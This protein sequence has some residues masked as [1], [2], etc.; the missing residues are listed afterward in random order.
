MPSTQSDSCSRTSSSEHYEYSSCGR[1]RKPVNYNV[2][3]MTDVVYEKAAEELNT[4]ASSRHVPSKRKSTG[5]T[6]SS[7]SSKK[8]RTDAPINLDQLCSYDRISTST[9]EVPASKKFNIDEML[10]A[11]SGGF[12]M[13]IRLCPDHVFFDVC[14]TI[15]EEVASNARMFLQNAESTAQILRYAWNKMSANERAKWEMMARLE[16]KKLINVEC[17]A[18][19]NSPAKSAERREVEDAVL[20]ISGEVD[21]DRIGSMCPALHPA[22]EVEKEVTEER[23]EPGEA[24][25]AR[26][27]LLKLPSMP[28]CETRFRS[29]EAMDADERDN[30]LSLGVFRCWACPKKKNIVGVAAFQVHLIE[31]HY[32]FHLYGCHLCLEAFSCVD[33][34]K[35]HPCQ[36]FAAYTIGLLTSDKQFEMKHVMH[37]L[38]CAECNVQMPLPSGQNDVCTRKLINLMRVHS[39]ERLI[40]CLVFFPELPRDVEFVTVRGMEIKSAI[41]T[42]CSECGS[43]FITVFDIEKHAAE[44]AQQKLKCPM[45]PRFFFTQLFY[46]DHLA[47]HLGDQF[48]VSPI[49]ESCT[50]VPPA[51]MIHGSTKM[52]SKNQPVRGLLNALPPS[53]SLQEEVSDGEDVT[54]ARDILVRKRLE[55]ETGEEKAKKSKEREN[56]K[57]KNGR[58]RFDNRCIFCK[59]LKQLL[60]KSR[61]SDLCRC[62][63]WPGFASS[64]FIVTKSEDEVRLLMHSL[65]QKFTRVGRLYVGAKVPVHDTLKG[66]IL[67][68]SVYICVKCNALHVGEQNTLRHLRICLQRNVDAPDPEKS[69]DLTDENVAL[70]LTNP[71]SALN[72]RIWCPRCESKCCSIASLRRHLALDHGIF[73]HFN[74][75]EVMRNIGII[76][77]SGSLRRLPT[78]AE[79]TN[80]KL[81][82]LKSG[83]FK[84]DAATGH[85]IFPKVDRFASLQA[86]N[87]ASQQGDSYARSGP[88]SRGPPSSTSSS[89]YSTPVRVNEQ[90]SISNN[91]VNMRNEQQSLINGKECIVCRAEFDSVQEVARH[92]VHEHVHF[93]EVC[94]VAFSEGTLLEVHRSSCTP[95]FARS[96]DGEYLPFCGICNFTLSNPKRYFYHIANFHSERFHFDHA[97]GKLLPAMMWKKLSFPEVSKEKTALTDTAS[98]VLSSAMSQPAHRQ[99]T[100]SSSDVLVDSGSTNEAELHSCFLCE[101][102]FACENI[103]REHLNAHEERWMD[104]PVCHSRGFMTFPI[105]S[106]EDL[107]K[108]VVAKHMHRSDSQQ[109]V[110]MICSLCCTCIKGDSSDPMSIRRIQEQMFRHIIYLCNGVNS[111]FVCNNGRNIRPDD[112]RKHRLNAHSNIYERFGCSSCAKKFF[113]QSDFTSHLCNTRLRC[114]CGDRND[115]TEREFECHFRTHVNHMGDFCLLCNKFLPSKQ[116]Q[117]SHLN[118]HRSVSVGKR[119]MIDL[120][121]KQRSEKRKPS[122][123]KKSEE[124]GTGVQ[125]ASSLSMA[126]MKQEKEDDD[127]V[128]V[129]DDLSEGGASLISPPSTKQVS[130]TISA[131]ESIVAQ[132]GL[133]GTQPSHTVPVPVNFMANVRM[134]QDN[135]Y[136]EVSRVLC[137]HSHEAVPLINILDETDEEAIGNLVEKIIAEV[138]GET[139]QSDERIAAS[140]SSCTS[141]SRSSHVEGNEGE[142]LNAA[143]EVGETRDD[144]ADAEDRLSSNGGDG[145]LVIDESSEQTVQTFVVTESTATEHPAALRPLEVGGEEL[146]AVVEESSG[147]LSA[148]NDDDEVQILNVVEGTKSIDQEQCVSHEANEAGNTEVGMLKPSVLQSCNL[149]EV[150]DGD[151]DLQVIAA[152]EGPGMQFVK[153]RAPHLRCPHCT[154]KFVTRASLDAHIASHRYDAGNTIAS[155]YGVPQNQLVYLCRLCCLAYESKT[156][157]DKH[158]RTHGLMQNCPHCCVVTFIEEQMRQHLTQHSLEGQRITYICAFC[159]NTYSSDERLCHHMMRN[160]RMVVMYFCKN[161]GIG[162]TNGQLVYLHIVRNECVS[163]QVMLVQS[164]KLGVAPASMFHYQ[165][166]DEAGYVDAVNQGALVV[167]QPSECVH[168]SFLMPQNEHVMVTC[169]DCSGLMS[170]T[171]LQSEKPSFVTSLPR[172]LNRGPDDSSIT[173]TQLVQIWKS[174]SRQKGRQAASVRQPN[175]SE[176]SNT[177]RAKARTRRRRA[178]TTDVQQEQSQSLVAGNIAVVAPQQAQQ[179]SLTRAT[180]MAVQHSQS[181]APTSIAPHCLPQSVISQAV[182]P[183]T[184]VSQQSAPDA[185]RSGIHH[186]VV[187]SGNA[188]SN[189]AGLPAFA[190]M[191]QSLTRSAS[192]NAVAMR[193]RTQRASGPLLPSG[194]EQCSTTRLQTFLREMQQ[195]VQRQAPVPTQPQLQPSAPNINARLQAPTAQAIPYAQRQPRAVNAHSFMSSP[196][197]RATSVATSGDCSLAQQTG[198]SVS[199][200]YP[201]LRPQLTVTASTPGGQIPAERQYFAQRISSTVQPGIASDQREALMGVSEDFIVRNSRGELICKR[202]ECAGIRIEKVASGHVHNL[203]HNIQNTY[204]CL[205]CGRAFPNEQLAIKHQIEIHHNNRVPAIMLR[206]PF[207]QWRPIFETMHGFKNHLVSRGEHIGRDLRFPVRW[208]ECRCELAFASDEARRVHEKEHRL[209]KSS[210]C[211][212]LCGTSRGFWSLPSTATCPPLEHTYI[213]AF[214]LWGMCRECG[215][216]FPNEPKKEQFVRHYQQVHWVCGSS[217]C[218]VCDIVIHPHYI[219]EHALERHFVVGIKTDRMRPFAVTVNESLLGSY[220]GLVTPNDAET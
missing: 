139:E 45:C 128:I 201:N 49:V 110:T 86:S 101:K 186:S 56:G 24:E 69:F 30:K 118:F 143:P 119:R 122:T 131:A 126:E 39:C 54:I 145:V 70:R 146:V 212:L 80:A 151:D 89:D 91:V 158:M 77:W 46:R 103:L 11:A 187:V 79:M 127:D 74:P 192:S 3:Y 196:V 90:G 47:S 84:V 42:A 125:Q 99:I 7:Y 185:S 199:A 112:L 25:V 64:Q 152:G 22:E 97:T 179:G 15:D 176:T 167:V 215:L 190:N 142:T 35:R 208:T 73:A 154:S 76:E 51:W 204:F 98:A 31:D 206:C 57:K 170:F 124:S 165:P 121:E 153:K 32:S 148:E 27:L 19:K 164:S 63:G 66:G 188:Q 171:R 138:G 81:G 4:R 28:P 6:S 189:V 120:N 2:R 20:A 10:P 78:L 83:E 58:K 65:S 55:K 41:P 36:D 147:N 93:C 62:D 43:R 50:L 107:L 109:D 211:C 52:G 132:D 160:H 72:T 141:S 183:I 106:H 67:I 197:Q 105:V 202:P 173:I 219:Q 88:A 23:D 172:I 155:V 133:V 195:A 100:S 220:L 40:S 104:C 213:H 17:V 168:R 161:C 191:M 13:M 92:L 214:S 134:E 210:G 9:G 102:K 60:P 116:Q 37:T 68:D 108:H 169:P 156:V 113:V 178:Q 18:L 194:G 149:K 205:E 159:A 14:K 44:H 75:P 216:C 203:R 162:C 175:S 207:C 193:T 129:L 184:T 53:V 21:A 115:F 33:G 137:E 26:D 59:Q 29:V 150:A 217:R 140:D 182:L 94:G 209:S 34:L 180:N 38:V 218:H 123:S 95:Q 157:Y 144:C 16:V 200:E 181:I 48:S 12:R 85:R 5:S 130:E 198:D 177:C 135:E 136:A 166:A 87:S 82:L 163:Q 96:A 174:S 114:S 111:C 1:R 8:K 71:H 61:R 117:L